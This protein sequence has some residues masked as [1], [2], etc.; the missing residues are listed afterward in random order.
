[1]SALAW[2]VT[3]TVPVAALDLDAHINAGHSDAGGV[4][5]VQPGAAKKQTCCNCVTLGVSV[6]MFF[7]QSGAPFRLGFNILIT[8]PTTW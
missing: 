4:C 6:K 1:M 3:R 7:G 8:K 2:E 5:R